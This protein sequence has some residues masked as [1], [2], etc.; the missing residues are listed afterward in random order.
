MRGMTR[1]LVVLNALAVMVLG[2]G[3]IG[4]QASALPDSTAK[5]ID[6]VFAAWDHTTSPGCALGL[7][8][9]GAM[10]YSRGYGMSDLQY[11]LAI[12]PASIFHV[13][14]ISK[15]FTAFSVALLGQDGKLSVDDDFRKYVPEIP[16]YGKKITIRQLMYHV[17][18]LRDQWELL[19]L[20]GWRFSEDLITEDDVLKIVARQKGLNF[21]PGDEYL[22][23][24]TGYTLLAVIVKRVSGKSLREFA[25][26]RI[27]RPLGMTS[28]HFHDD[29]TMIVRNRTSAY[30]PRDGGGWKI[31]I[32]VFDTYGATSLFTTVGDLLKWEQNFADGKIG[33]LALLK[34][35]TTSAV[36]NNK[37]P[38]NYGFG[39]SMGTYRGAAYVG[40]GGADAGYRA[41]V[42]RFPQQGV[43]IAALCNMANAG[44]G[45]LTRAVADIVLEKLEPVPAVPASVTLTQA[46]VER[47][48]GA[49]KKV[50]SDDVLWVTASGGRLLLPAFGVALIPRNDS[51]FMIREAPY[52]FHFVRSTTGAEELRMI[53]DEGTQVYQR[54]PAFHPTAVQL[55]GYAGDYYSDE[56]EA[57]YSLVQLDSN[58]VLRTRKHPDMPLQPVFV[59]GFVVGPLGT[60]R[61][62]RVGAKVTSFAVT[63]GR[64]RGLVFARRSSTPSAF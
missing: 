6:Q 46:Q 57:R 33:G 23:S 5:K 55:Q 31:S 59:D 39:L 50:G 26:E 28:T 4:A 44:P 24:N 3:Q 47:R 56:L 22:Y 61:F 37:R 16:D 40:H 45:A 32:P 52:E 53:T 38:T 20:A 58:L 29:H 49:F 14:S 36:L 18:G 13:A 10:I 54:L 63:G 7:T 11:D 1:V 41:D 8:K 43:A 19:G 35:A 42:I 17:S 12:T 30:E 62:T 64:V 25:D 15:Q 51:V 21:N 9:D 60:L 27:F 34:E 48:A 2:Q